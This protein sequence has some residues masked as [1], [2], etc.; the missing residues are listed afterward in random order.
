MEG[1]ALAKDNMALACEVKTLGAVAS[2]NGETLTDM[3][4][5]TTQK[6]KI[7]DAA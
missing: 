6:V 2:P 1:H 4:Y 5:F 7:Y 3:V